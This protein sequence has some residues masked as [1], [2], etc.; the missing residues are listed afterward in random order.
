MAVLGSAFLLLTLFD[1][2]SQMRSIEMREGI[3][4]FLSTPPGDG[5]GLTVESTIEILRVLTLVAG[6]ASA[7]A[8]VLA[9][10]VL[11]RNKA[12]RL[13]FTIA[14][15]PIALTAPLSGGFLAV[16]V[17]FSASMLW[18]KP[19]R[20]WFAGRSP[21]QSGARQARA[22]MSSGPS[23]DRPAVHKSGQGD[24]TSPSYPA[25]NPDASRTP[26][27]EWPRMPDPN[28]PSERP[29]PPPTQ[30][31]GSPTPPSQQGGQDS[32]Q[33]PPQYPQSAQPPQQGSGSY[34][35]QDQGGPYPQ[36]HSWPPPAYGQQPQQYS[37]G[38]DWGQQWGPQRDPDKR[39]TT[40]TTAAVLTWIFAGLTAALYLLLVLLLIV[41]ADQLLTALEQEPALAEMNIDRDTVVAAL[42]VVS[43]VLIFWCFAAAVLAFFA[44]RRANWARYTLVVSAVFSAIFSL[45]AIASLV[46]VLPLIASIAVI[47]LLFTGGANQ[48][49]S[50]KPGREQYAQQYG[51]YGGQGQQGQYGQ[52]QYGDQG[53]QGQGQYGDQ[54]QQE[55]RKDPPKNVW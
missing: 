46:S 8:L 50:R 47:V 22:N 20:D 38:Q 27:Q 6:A 36:G 23:E 13:G 14:A 52:G 26:G 55:E 28:N 29:G 24:D 41:D 5:L 25:N 2:M 7:A 37:G 10:Y 40:V 54:G 3:E 32:P 19:A 4:E 35:Q 12:A 18:T 33:Y 21:A 43:A 44:L 49:Y 17:V 51:G 9:I 42:W 53:Q 31:F 48:W 15:V 1:L 30:G 39:P 45:L 11:Q 16:V 34:P